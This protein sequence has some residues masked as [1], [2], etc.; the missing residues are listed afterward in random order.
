MYVPC[1]TLHVQWCNNDVSTAS[2][3]T[4][5]R[6]HADNMHQMCTACIGLTNCIGVSQMKKIIYF[7][8]VASTPTTNPLKN[9]SEEKNLRGK[10][11]MKITP[12]RLHRVHH[13]L[14]DNLYTLSNLPASSFLYMWETRHPMIRDWY[15][16][17]PV[18]RYCPDCYT[19]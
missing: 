11:Q 8:H 6:V 14:I 13:K 18:R 10:N 1:R 15:N 3:N 4:V 19:T 5:H 2:K 17:S 9:L 7:G 16:C 12:Y